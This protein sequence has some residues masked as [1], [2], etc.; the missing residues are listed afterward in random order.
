MNE[1]GEG[2]GAMKKGNEGHL[3]GEMGLCDRGGKMEAGCG[4]GLLMIYCL[5]STSDKNYLS[6]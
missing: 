6:E 1:C 3:M 2:V 5:R 4:G